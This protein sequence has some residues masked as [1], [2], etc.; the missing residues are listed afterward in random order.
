MSISSGTFETQEQTSIAISIIL[1]E[2]PKGSIG[3][4]LKQEMKRQRMDKR[5]KQMA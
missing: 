1:D 5:K 3:K 2:L 4:T